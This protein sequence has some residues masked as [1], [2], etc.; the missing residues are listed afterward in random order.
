MRQIFTDWQEKHARLWGRHPIRLSHSLH[1]SELFSRDALIDLVARYPREHYSVIH[2]GAG[3][4]R[5]W[6]EG[7]F[8]A[9]DGA[10]M[11]E[12]IEAGR[13]WLNL[14]CADT[15]DAAY[16]S[17][18][19]QMFTEIAAHTGRSDFPMASLGILVS[20]PDAQ[21]YYHSDLP[22]QSLWQIAGR[23]R[24][25]VYPNTEPFLSDQDLERIAIFE[26]EVDLAYEPWYDE[27]A[28]SFDLE[29]GQML[30]WP[31]NAPH[32]VQ[33]LGCLNVSVTTEYWAA[34]ARLAHQVNMAN[35]T[36]RHGLGFSPTNRATSGPGFWARRALNAVVSRTGWLE[37][38]RTANKPI[39]FTA[40][41]SAGITAKPRPAAAE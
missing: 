37:K 38:V 9:R 34:D 12:A 7:E 36:L 30:H 15:V 11:F 5:Y 6:K 41:A 19:D 1:E 2:M 3:D 28:V 27:H 31:L 20:S 29:P 13:L 21:V 32:R 4:E 35:G 17:L 18:L 25:W 24:V 14:R 22:N 26:K 23:K 33:N 8:G 16:R 10:A 39:E 40:D